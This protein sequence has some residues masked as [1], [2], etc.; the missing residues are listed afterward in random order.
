MFRLIF[1]A[2][3]GEE[4]MGEQARR[5]LHES[6][7]SMTAPLVALAALSVAGGWIGLPGWLGEN[8]FERFLEPSL[9]LARK[10]GHEA[11]SHGTELGLALVSV[12]VAL[13]G[14]YAAYRLYAGRPA[15]GPKPRLAA[16]HRLLS[17]KYFVD[18][19]YDATLVH[20]ILDAARDVL[21]RRIDV[22]LI[23]GA[24]NGV[25]EALGGAAA[26]LRNIQNG[27]VR[28]YAAWILFGA[29]AVLM[30]VYTLVRG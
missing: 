7:P 28:S 20:P 15:L 25:G 18:E 12:A 22:G 24:V 26:L 8:R 9:A 30:Y 3:Y 27:L 21:W 23:D 10:T 19:I 16:L 29:V 17:R 4:R 13:T 14:I 6:P 1:L 2:F 5:H 11:T